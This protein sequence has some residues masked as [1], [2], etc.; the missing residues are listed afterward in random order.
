MT[1]VAVLPA[2]DAEAVLGGGLGL[3]E[4]ACD[5]PV[6]EEGLLG[7]MGWEDSHGDL[8][9]VP[10]TVMPVMPGAEH[11]SDFKHMISVHKATHR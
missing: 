7:R 3:K 11:V 9:V 6:E 4:G 8:P 1:V 10:P 2:A 5:V